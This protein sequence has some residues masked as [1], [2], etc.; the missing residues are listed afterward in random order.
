[1]ITSNKRSEL[2]KDFANLTDYSAKRPEGCRS[3]FAFVSFEDGSECLWSNIFA[4]DRGIANAMVIEKFADCLPYLTRFT[5][6]EAD[7]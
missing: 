6:Q 4:A 3:F 7:Y 1:M 2:Q 5:L